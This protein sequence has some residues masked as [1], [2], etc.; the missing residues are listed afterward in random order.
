LADAGLF[1]MEALGITPEGTFRRTALG[2]RTQLGGEVRAP[3]KPAQKSAA[4]KLV[5][6]GIVLI[7]RGAKFT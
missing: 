1:Y 5:R 4:K 7:T 3:C 2:Q 6:Y